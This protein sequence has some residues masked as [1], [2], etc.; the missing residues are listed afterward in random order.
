MLNKTKFERPE[1]DTDADGNP[2]SDTATKGVPTTIRVNKATEEKEASDQRFGDAVKSFAGNFMAG[3]AAGMASSRNETA[4]TS[5]VAM[6]RAMKVFDVTQDT[7]LGEERGMASA[8]VSAFG[9]AEQKK[10]IFEEDA[11]QLTTYKAGTSQ[12]FETRVPKRVQNMIDFDK[13]FG[14]R[15]RAEQKIREEYASQRLKRGVTF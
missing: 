9:V 14:E 3:V 7:K 11:R 2:I 10:K 6:Q 13:G 15:M 5:G 8:K 12:P 4:R 1:F